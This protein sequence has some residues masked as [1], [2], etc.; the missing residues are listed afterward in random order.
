MT[1]G[2]SVAGNQPAPCR[3]PLIES[4][5]APRW[6]AMAASIPGGP[7]TWL[8]SFG[9]S[10]F[11]LL[12]LTAHCAAGKLDPDVVGTDWV[13]HDHTY[14][15][16]RFQVKTTEQPDRA[17]HVFKYSLDVATYN[18]LRVGSS[19]GFLALVVVHRPHPAWIGPYRTGSIVRA[20]AHWA[21]LD[22]MPETTNTSS[23]TIPVPA[24]NVLTP[25]VLYELVARGGDGND[26]PD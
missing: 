15:L 21:K 19:P 6:R 4:A 20:S 9:E 13:V 18:R 10:W 16:S 5:T 7:E 1:G 23:V 3:V 26:E 25:S 17:G 14:E 22:G 12:C 8:G 24:P 2:T 11:K